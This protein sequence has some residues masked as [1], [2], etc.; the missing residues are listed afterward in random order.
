[1][2]MLVGQVSRVRV[3]VYT[4]NKRCLNFFTHQ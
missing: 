3:L 4:E 2:L 1:M